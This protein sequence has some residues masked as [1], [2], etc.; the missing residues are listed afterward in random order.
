MSFKQFI[1]T[2]PACGKIL[3]KCEYDSACGI[4]VQCSKCGTVLD[5]Q[6]CKKVLKVREVE[7]KYNAK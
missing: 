7:L 2:C 6:Q 5:V 3:F 4:E 1:V